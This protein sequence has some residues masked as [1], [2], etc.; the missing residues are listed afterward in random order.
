MP[1]LH[2][3]IGDLYFRANRLHDALDSYERAIR[4]SPE[5]GEDV[6]LKLG[7]IRMKRKERDEAVKC[8]EQALRLDPANAVAKA[9]LAT[10]RTGA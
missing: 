8:W 9:K 1:Q 7:E 3:N 2:K 10:V 6:Y 4:S 5:L